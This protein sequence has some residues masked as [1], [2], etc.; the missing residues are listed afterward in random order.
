M[1]HFRN[2]LRVMLFRDSHSEQDQHVLAIHFHPHAQVATASVMP[3][4]VL[5]RPP[6][7]LGLSPVCC[8]T[9]SNPRSLSPPRPFLQWRP[10]PRYSL[11]AKVQCSLSIDVNNENARPMVPA[12]CIASASW[13][14]YPP[15]VFLVHV[16]GCLVST[17]AVLVQGGTT[18][19]FRMENRPTT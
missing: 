1:F 17:K 3:T 15:G 11:L 10:Q 8:R 2:V 4:T 5:A 19:I 14:T 16:W 6:V 9:R 18:F 12:G 13:F 7:P